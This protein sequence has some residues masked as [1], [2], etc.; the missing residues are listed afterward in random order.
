MNT[1]SAQDVLSFWFEEISPKQQFVKDEQFDAE[2]KR[3]FGPLHASLKKDASSFTSTPKGALAAILV[4]D[5]FSRNMFRGSGQAF[6]TDPLALLIAKD[7]ITS[8]ADKTMPDNHRIFVYMPFMHAETLEDQE[9][10]VAL[11]TALG[12]TSNIAYANKHHDVV[13]KYGRFP[14]R[15]K[16]IDRVSSP[17]EKTFINTPG[18]AF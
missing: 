13:K 15:N 6:D 11:F 5:Q 4:F 9:Q 7:L 18:T 1:P 2:I 10:S 3:R 8:G 16:A 14:H 12:I 17:E